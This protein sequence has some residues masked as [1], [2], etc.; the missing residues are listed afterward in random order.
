MAA[1]FETAV[2]TRGDSTFLQDSIGSMVSKVLAAKVMADKERTYAQ[3]QALKQGIDEAEFNTMVPRGEF[4]RKALIGEFGG[5][6]VKKKKQELA[7]LYRKGLLLGKITKNKRLRGKVLGQVKESLIYSKA[8]LKNAKKFRSQFDY[9]DYEEYFNPQDKKV[10][11][12]RKKVQNAIGGG[13]G[14]RVSR[15]QI[16]E[17]IDAIAKSIERTAQSITQSSSSVY[18]TLITANQLQAD[19]AQDLKIRNT[20]LEDKLQKLVDVI[21]NQTQVQ[22]DFIDKKEEIQQEGKLEGKR[23]AA[24]AETPDDLRTIVNESRTFSTFANE[25]EMMDPYLRQPPEVRPVNSMVNDT[26]SMEA[27]GYPKAERGGTFGKGGL[28]LHGTEALAS[29]SGV[30]IVSGPDSGYLHK[31]DEPT[32]VVP[33]NNNFTQGEK[34]AVTGKVEPKPKTPM[35]NS[36]QKFEMGTKNNFAPAAL[37]INTDA[38]QPLIDAMELIPMAAGGGALALTSEYVKVLG[39]SAGQ[40]IAPEMS[41][42]QRPLASVFGLN[43]SIVTKATGTKTMAKKKEEED[44]PKEGDDKNK[45]GIFDKLKEGFGKFMELLGKKI[46]DVD[47]SGDGGAGGDGMGGGGTGSGGSGQDFATLA[48]VAALESGSAQGRA[49][50]AQSVYNRLGD[51][52]YGS[53]ITDILTRQGQYQ[54]AFKDPKASSGAGTQIAD[55]FKNIKTEDDAVKAIMYYYKARGQSITADRAR[56]MYRESASA[57][58]DPKLRQ[59]ASAYV[60]GR[61]E[62]RGYRTGTSGEVHRGGKSDNYFSVQYGS[63]KQI[64]RGAV[65]APSG[66]FNKPSTTP[67][68]PIAGNP[69]GALAAGQRPDIIP[70]A[71]QQR[72]AIAARAEADRLGLTGKAKDKF[73]AEKVMAVPSPIFQRPS[74][75]SQAETLGEISTNPRQN[76]KPQIVALNTGGSKPQTAG[77]ATPPSLGDSTIPSGRNPLKDSGLYIG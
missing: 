52:S 4:F 12:T 11:N 61:T 31:I 76:V 53:S 23:A 62:F 30:K 2:D 9:T 6:A 68:T 35:I 1:G 63:G 34:S 39:E 40:D 19:V 77:A 73:V 27:Y 49:D 32:E 67:A 70:S 16:I 20:T 45:K 74:Q 43:S 21:S 5:F 48:T 57:I 26:A 36:I 24:G 17:S 33:L 14:K 54:V 38:S 50:V 59:N 18:G 42:L 75:Q 15:E 46:N 7:A 72:V 56:K 44:K 65:A 22:K 66:L 8:N 28:E 69:P 13:S 55:V 29:D 51:G 64:A 10:P 58:S 47:T 3:K 25:Q 60:Q 37:N 71:E 41:K